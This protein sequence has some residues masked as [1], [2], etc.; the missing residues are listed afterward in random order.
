MKPILF[1]ISIVVAAL[2]LVI[3]LYGV[4]PIRFFSFD[5]FQKVNAS[6]FYTFKVY[7]KLMIKSYC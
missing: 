1:R 2:I 6:L 7:D 5:F 4:V 3:L